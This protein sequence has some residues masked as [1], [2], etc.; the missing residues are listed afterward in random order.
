MYGQIHQEAIIIRIRMIILHKYCDSVS[1][2]V[3]V[4]VT[5][6]ECSKFSQMDATKQI[7]ECPCNFSRLI[8]N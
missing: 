2:M 8:N 7:Y 6:S 5:L 1:E 3:K 4:I